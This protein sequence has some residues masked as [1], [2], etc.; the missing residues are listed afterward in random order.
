MSTGNL[1][2]F[3]RNFKNPK[4]FWKSEKNGNSRFHNFGKID[5]I[6]LPNRSNRSNRKK[7]LNRLDR[8]IGQ[9]INRYGSSKN[10]KPKTKLK[11]VVRPNTSK[12]SWVL[13]V[14]KG[15]APRALFMGFSCTLFIGFSPKWD[16]T[17][18]Y[19]YIQGILM[20]W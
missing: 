10:Q 2:F 20:S 6:I 19:F 7:L 18:R 3:P 9:R 8:F 14:E 15:M 12:G 1:E 17:T 16:D 11:I 4:K 13:Q 5:L